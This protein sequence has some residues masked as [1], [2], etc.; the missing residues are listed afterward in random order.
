MKTMAA[1]TKFNKAAIIKRANEVVI[2]QTKRGT[3]ITKDG[4]EI[5][6]NYTPTEQYEVVQFS[7]AVLMLLNAIG[8]MPEKTYKFYSV[9]YQ[10]VNK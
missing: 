2:T 4:G 9:D 10:L 6:S 8:K 7:V 1:T 3:V 5:V